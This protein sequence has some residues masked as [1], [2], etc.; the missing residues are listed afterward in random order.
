MAFA[1]AVL[2]ALTTLT[3][4]GGTQ[5]DITPSTRKSLSVYWGQNVFTSGPYVQKGLSYYCQNEDIDIFPLAFLIGLNGPG[6]A[7]VINFSNAGNNCTTFN[8]TN[9]L[10][11]PQ[12]QEDI[13]ICQNLGKTILLSFGGAT[14]H[15]GGFES[16][17]AAIAGAELLWN[18]FGPVPTS[19]SS[20]VLRPFG[21]AVVDG[22]DL[23]FES[24]VQNMP[25]FAN[26]LREYYTA[27][28]SKKYY[29]TAAPQCVFP[30]AAM[31][32]MLDG[33]V[34]FDA[35]WVQFYNNNCGLNSFTQGTKEQSD[36]NFERWNAWAHRASKNPNVR[37][38]V[39]V[40]A[41]PEA[42]GSGYEPLADLKP[43]IDYAASFNSFGGVMM[44]DA[45]KAYSNPG[46]IDGV[47]SALEAQ[48]SPTH[49]F[50]TFAPTVTPVPKW[51]QFD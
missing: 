27:D 22:F 44:W 25:T 47:A 7:P 32:A 51:G 17:S 6:D 11:C 45:S 37:V 29:L 23:D 15:G 40:P 5:A 33:T 28:A 49:V 31:G 26:K 38:Y 39:G 34:F 48:P 2:F 12:I 4:L 46:F 35:I 30:D 18:T 13:K 3:V 21:D 10:R 36:F 14:Y 20:E 24:Q 1:K 50:P 8:N 43:I 19:N 41:S 9:L 16:E 42:A